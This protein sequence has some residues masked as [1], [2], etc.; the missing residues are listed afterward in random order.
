MIR[1]AVA[2]AVAAWLIIQIV[3]T[4]FPAFGFS[5]KA[6]RVVVIAMGIGFLPAVIAA[7]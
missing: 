6:V 5:D 1:V 2:Y 4:I 7:I 3:E